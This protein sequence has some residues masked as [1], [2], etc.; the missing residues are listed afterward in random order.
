VLIK[1]F[2]RLIVAKYIKTLHGA[3]EYAFGSN[4]DLAEAE[5]VV[6]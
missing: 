6:G 5:Q 3:C 1:A 2:Y 4:M